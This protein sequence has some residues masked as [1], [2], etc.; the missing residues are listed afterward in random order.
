MTFQ[1][2]WG[3][4]LQHETL[5]NDTVMTVIKNLAE[6]AWNESAR[7]VIACSISDIA[8]VRRK[9]K[10]CANCGNLIKSEKMNIHRYHCKENPNLVL[11][12]ITTPC[13]SHW[14]EI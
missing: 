3:D 13:R 10:C 8:E 4:T 12:D 2:W 5:P 9:L 1:E 14:R 6:R 7:Q 11:T